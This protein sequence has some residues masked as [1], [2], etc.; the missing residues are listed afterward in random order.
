[1][2]T[3]RE[4]VRA[5]R[6]VTRRIV[7]ALLSGEPETTDLPMRRLGLATFG[8]AL[9]AAI[10]MA[11]VGVYGLMNPGGGKPEANSIV[12]ERETGARYV[13]VED[14]LY[15][16]LNYASARLILGVADPT[17]QTLSRS[18]LLGL[19]RGSP[20]GITNAPDSLPD[21]N[22]LLGVPWSVCSAPRSADAPTPATHL[23]IGSAPSGGRNLGDSGL[24]VTAEGT[25]TQYLLWGN[26]RLQVKNAATLSALGMASATSVVVGQALINA[27]TAGPDLGGITVDQAD[28]I[29][30]RDVNGHKVTIGTMYHDDRGQHYVMTVDGLV[31]VGPTMAALMLAVAVSDE[32]IAASVAGAE[33]SSKKV[34]P[35]GFPQAVPSLIQPGTKQVAACAIYQ[36]TADTATPAIVLKLFD[37]TPAQLTSTL[38]ASAQTSRGVRTVDYIDV[39][40]GAGALVQGLSGSGA[41]DSGSTRYLVTDQGIKY[42]L[43]TQNGD[44]LTALG[45]GASTPQQVPLTFLTLIPSGP[46]LDIA[47]AK[48][49]P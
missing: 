26:R 49:T 48:N 3:R 47:A 44:G 25:N 12:I 29:S 46:T 2:Q 22:N 10:V 31:T 21:K 27:T 38:D 36:R 15:P 41:T 8:S 34:E 17:V 24:L 7:S 23:L 9:V 20:R 32:R 39:A 6:F 42:P 18:S 43:A 35:E 33:L 19:D 30:S 28:S 5:Y 11:G 40:G 16:V 4:Q 37:D 1:M 14:R 13:Y 45:Y